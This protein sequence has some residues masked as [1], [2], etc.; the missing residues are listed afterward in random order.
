[1]PAIVWEVKERT[2]VDVLLQASLKN[3]PLGS[4][5]CFGASSLTELVCLSS[6]ASI[7]EL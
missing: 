6:V 3:L 5:L 7:R 4:G 1:M 2:L